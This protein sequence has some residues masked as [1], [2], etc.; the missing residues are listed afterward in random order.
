MKQSQTHRY[1]MALA[2]SLLLVLAACSKGPT[3]DSISAAIKSSYFSDAAVKNEPIEIAVTN[4]EVTLTGK[5]SSDAARLQAYKLAAGTPGVKKVNDKME[6]GPGMAGPA[7]AME[8]PPQLQTEPVKEDATKQSEAPPA[9]P[10][11][12]VAP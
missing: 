6:V 10:Q 11:P 2:M 3:D 5:V 8:Q 1:R 9:A 7:M 12:D 4:G